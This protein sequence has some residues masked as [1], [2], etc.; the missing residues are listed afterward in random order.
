MIIYGI[1]R[2]YGRTDRIPGLLF[3]GTAFFHLFFIPIIPMGSYLVMVKD[4]EFDSFRGIKIP[5]S[6]KSW[7]YGW[8]RAA[9]LLTLPIVAWGFYAAYTTNIYSDS[10]YTHWSLSPGWNGF[11]A[12]GIAI[13][14]WWIMRKTSVASEARQAELMRIAGLRF[15]EAP[16]AA[17]QPT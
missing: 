9:A 7:L 1:N 2:L 16:V 3:V 15:V 12:V 4:D 6:I 10:T 17:A 14:A 13:A 5:F 11:L 8:G